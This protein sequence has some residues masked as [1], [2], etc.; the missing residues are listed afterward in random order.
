MKIPSELSLPL[1]FPARGYLS[2]G[3]HLAQELGL[4]AL[5]IA[6]YKKQTVKITPVSFLFILIPHRRVCSVIYITQIPYCFVPA[7]T[8]QQGE[9]R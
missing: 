2:Q 6:L 1:H 5:S 9:D 8:H 3:L 4:I 7:S